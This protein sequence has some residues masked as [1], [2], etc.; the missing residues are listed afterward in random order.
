MAKTWNK[1]SDF[2][3]RAFYEEE[4]E[5]PKEVEQTAEEV[6]I[7]QLSQEEMAMFEVSISEES[8]EDIARATTKEILNAINS[9]NNSNN[10]NCGCNN[11]S[12]R[13]SH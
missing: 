1:F 2:L 8:I 7:P 4:S 3:S 12:Y 11:R 5:P 13:M 6:E 10:S 9:N